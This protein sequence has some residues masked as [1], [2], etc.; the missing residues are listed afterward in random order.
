M[1]CLPY[2]QKKNSPKT[3]CFSWQANQNRRNA[4]VRTKTAREAAEQAVQAQT[5]QATMRREAE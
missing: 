1:K 5:D 2:E 4:E 3:D